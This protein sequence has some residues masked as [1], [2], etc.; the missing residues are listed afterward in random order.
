MS[1][2]VTRQYYA[3]GRDR[4]ASRLCGS[5]YKKEW[6]RKTVLNWCSIFHWQKPHNSAR[7]PEK[8][9]IF[10]VGSYVWLYLLDF[11]ETEIAC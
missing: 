8:S 7:P 11:A 9:N 6:K 2:V 3:S 5:D 4:D 1:T 10:S